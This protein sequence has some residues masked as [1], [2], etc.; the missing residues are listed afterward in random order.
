M[1]ILLIVALLF[2]FN[3]RTVFA[4]NEFNVSQKIKYQISTDGSAYIN[5]EIDL[6]N[7]LSQ[8]YPKE[9]Q[10][11]LSF[12]DITNVR[13]YDNVGNILQSANNDGDKTSILLKFNRPAVGKDQVTKFY[14]NYNVG[15]F[16]VNKGRTWE[17]TLPQYQIDESTDKLLDV[18]LLVPASFGKIS[19]SSIVTPTVEVGS[20]QTTINLN[21]NQIKNRKIL[22]IF[23]DFQLYDFNL[24][25]YLH[26]TDSNPVDTEIAI[27]PDT[28][29]QKINYKS[30][31][32]KPFDIK[33][34]PDGN[35]LAQYHLSGNQ[36]INVEAIGQA[37]ISPPK[38]QPE[39]IDQAELT[40]E[41]P[42]WPI[43]NP[44]IQTIAKTMLQPKQIYDY[45][46]STLSYDYEL[47]NTSGRKGALVA[48][49]TPEYSLC[50]EFTDLFVTLARA[51]H[52]PAREIEGYAITNNLKI[53]PIN[54]NTDIL[55]AWPQYFDTNTK[56]WI[57]IDPTWA[58]TTNGIDYFHELDLNHLT[59]VTHGI[60]SDYPPPPGSHK[61]NSQ[62]KTVEVK[63]ANQELAMTL[64]PVTVNLSPTNLLNPSLTLTVQ[65]PNL[66]ALNHVTLSHLGWNTEIKTIPPLG[67]FTYSFPKKNFISSIMPQNKFAKI[68]VT[69]DEITESTVQ[70]VRDPVHYFNLTIFISILIVLLCILG[71]ILSVTSR[72]PKSKK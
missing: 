12:S 36:T 3:P 38:F 17:I 64:S 10:V 19:F 48:I 25:Y 55:H 49:Q 9:Y 24:K 72:S 6:S 14:L 7:N 71:I 33:I 27:P 37:K 18:T 45:V 43:S 58:K 51:N 20:N 62:T 52:I 68:T 31:L 69:S 66:S 29:Y 59:F 23:G 54:T 21:L 4:A 22:F 32:P 13:A 47:T 60:Q 40:K 44:E 65:N 63:F 1:L 42:Y 67:S 39:T 50:T 30:I 70:N 26:N 53:K 5:Q 56:H 34:D 28:A 57:S 2:Q 61:Q 46:T 41:Q 35:W 8:V 16:A 15:N 11:D